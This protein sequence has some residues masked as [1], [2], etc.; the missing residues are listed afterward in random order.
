[1]KARD[2]VTAVAASFQAMEESYLAVCSMH[3]ENY[4][5]IEP[6]EFFGNIENFTAAFLVC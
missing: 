3:G 1:M 6:D 5:L 2:R 4:K